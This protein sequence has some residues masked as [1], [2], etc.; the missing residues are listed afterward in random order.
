MKFLLISDTHFSYRNKQ[1]LDTIMKPQIENLDYDCVLMAGDMV[2]SKNDVQPFL[3]EYFPN[4]KI[5]FIGGN[6]LPYYH[7]PLEPM[8][9]IHGEL[10]QKY[11]VDSDQTF[12][13]NGYKIIGNNVIICANLYTNFKYKGHRGRKIPCY[14][15]NGEPVDKNGRVLICHPTKTPEFQE[16]ISE[17]IS[18][19]LAERPDISKALRDL[20]DSVSPK[21]TETVEAF[22]ERA[23]EEAYKRWSDWF[24]DQNNHHYRNCTAKEILD[25]NIKK[26][27]EDINDFNSVLTVR[28]CHFPPRLVQPDDYIYYHDQTI[29]YINKI[30]KQFENTDYNIIVM[31]HFCPTSKM[32]SPVY[33]NSYNN[34]Y[35]YS[36][37]ER[38]I[39]NHPRI[40]L[41]LCGHSHAPME[42]QV[43][44]TKVINNAFGISQLN[45][46]KFWKPKIFEI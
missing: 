29:R 20:F 44:N 10:E 8:E 31:T 17:I 39:K 38:F 5:I 1:A 41:W 15:E 9:F 2:S 32:C 35:Y 36:E 16:R 37:D 3:D 13:E 6:H 11:P 25:F 24:E 45:E 27:L 18:A 43:G 42:A 46:C 22:R 30:Y 40:A 23:G 26:A 12:L 19:P 4:K 14:N 34:G 33:E 7:A 28:G 21:H